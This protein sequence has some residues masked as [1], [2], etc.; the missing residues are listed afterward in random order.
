[1]AD[2]ESRQSPSGNESLDTILMDAPSARA[3]LVLAH[4]AG[5]GM[6]HPFMA[7][8]ARALAEHGISTMRYQFPYM[9]AS[10]GSRRPDPPTVLQARVR[11]V[12]SHAM[13]TR[14]DVPVFAGGKSLGGRMTTAAA[15]RGWLSGV[16]GIVLFGFPLHPPKRPATSR[17]DH[18]SA[19]E[20]PVLFLQGTRDDL[21]DLSLLRPI[22]EQLA[23]AR[24]QNVTLHV[25]E[26]ADH[27]FGMLKRSG[28]SSSDVISELARTVSEWVTQLV[29]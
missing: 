28:R 11:D 14:P 1:M 6:H 24:P 7:T 5:A 17:A 22:C 3:L 13:L 23:T 19:V 25:I 21:A 20:L 12:V 16:R 10:A 4:G 9:E 2:G 8:I 29:R 26:G 27:S 15:A 18:L